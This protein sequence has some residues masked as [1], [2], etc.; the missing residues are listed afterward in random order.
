MSVSP[1][2]FASCAK[3][4]VVKNACY[5][6]DDTLLADEGYGITQLL[7]II[8]EIQ[9][10]IYNQ[11]H[12]TI[13]IEEPEIHLHP[14]YQSLLAEMFLDAYK[15]Y[16]IHFIIETHSEYL[17]RRFQ[18]LVAQHGVDQENGLDRKNLSIYYLYSPLDGDRPKEDPIVKEIRLRSDG[19]LKDKFGTG[20]VDESEKLVFDLLD[21][22]LFKRP[23]N[24]NTA[25]K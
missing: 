2:A 23:Q 20:F 4:E 15:N 19:T 6:D 16:G 13:I 3:I 1:V 25:N 5:S 11:T 7:S 10:A 8:L 24:D 12:P 22:S 14:K 18:T 21:I 9:T 17:I